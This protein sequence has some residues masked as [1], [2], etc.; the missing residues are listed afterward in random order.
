MA[1]LTPYVLVGAGSAVGGV[2]RHAL[3]QFITAHD[4]GEFPWGILTVNLIGC[5]V[6]GVAFALVERT[7]LKL[8]LMTGVL[9]GFTT[10]SAFSS[11]S[12]ELAMKGRW[13]LAGAYVTASVIG[14]LLAVWIGA[15][16]TTGLRGQSYS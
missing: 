6:M 3:A 14:C 12:M 7:E 4:P 15:V 16:V 2:L 1:D 5:L 9:G 10:F 11:I 8:L 13:D